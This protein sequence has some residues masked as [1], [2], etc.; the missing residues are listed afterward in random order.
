LEHDLQL[1]LGEYKFDWAQTAIIMVAL[2]ILLVLVAHLARR[3]SKR[4]DSQ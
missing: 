2:L 3:R 4:R 1:S